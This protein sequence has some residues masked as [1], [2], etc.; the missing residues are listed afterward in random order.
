MNLIVSF[1]GTCSNY[2]EQMIICI[3]KIP[4]KKFILER[5]LPES[6]CCDTNYCCKAISVIQGR[7]LSR[8]KSRRTINYMDVLEKLQ[9]QGI[10][11]RVASP[12]LVMEEVC[13]RVVD[14]VCPSFWE[15]GN[16]YA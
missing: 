8:S 12:K 5:W 13:H 2:N 9:R 1:K 6:N 11:I 3:M 16:T 15:V 7:A 4:Q 10:S 14:N